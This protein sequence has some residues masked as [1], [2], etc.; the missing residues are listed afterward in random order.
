MEIVILPR[1]AIQNRK[2]TGIWFSRVWISAPATSSPLSESLWDHGGTFVIDR[3]SVGG[4]A[5]IC[6][7][8]TCILWHPWD[9]C[10]SKKENKANCD[11]TDNWYNAFVSSS[12]S[13][14]SSRK[15]LC[16]K[17]AN[18]LRGFGNWCFLGYW[19][20]KQV[21]SWARVTDNLMTNGDGTC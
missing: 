2:Q 20:V 15:K 13:C 7:I 16:K 3:I 10:K 9:L 18:A 12:L 21:Y 1:M 4:H 17:F 6:Q 11:I 8:V 14:S 19:H 5:R